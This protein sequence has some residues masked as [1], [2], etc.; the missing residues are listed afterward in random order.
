MIGGLVDTLGKFKE[1]IALVVS[2]IVAFAAVANLKESADLAARIETLGVTMEVVGKN[3]GYTKE[4]LDGY[5]KEVK[6]LGITSEA[7]RDTIIQMTSAGLELGDVTG[8]GSSQ[9]A[10][11]ARASQDLAVI[12]GGSS[13]E[14]LQQ[15][16]TNL[17]QLDTKV[18]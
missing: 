10:Q 4:Q 12:M 8:K 17:Q 7:A 16:I 9:V 14:T 2:G 5:E 1:Q 6:A 18:S 15:M 13:S 11:L 3:A